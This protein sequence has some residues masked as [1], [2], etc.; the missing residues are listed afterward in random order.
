MQALPNIL[1]LVAEDMCP[2][3]GCYGNPD[4]R[5]PNL[6]RLASEGALYENAHSF[7]PICAPARSCLITGVYPTSM[8][9]Q[10]MRSKV[11]RPAAIRL[12]TEYLRDA[13]YYCFNGF[14]QQATQYG[15]LSAEGY[16]TKFDYNFVE[17]EERNPLPAWD[18][19]SGFFPEGSAAHWRNRQ[20]G[21]PFF[22]QIGFF[23][24][25]QSQYGTRHMPDT[26]CIPLSRVTPAERRSPNNVAVPPY[27]PDCD[28]V[29]QLWAEYHD[30]ITEM[31]HQVGEVLGALE[32]DGLT[33][34]TVVFF[35]GD[36]GMGVVGGKSWLWDQGTHVPLIVRVPEDLQSV[37]PI[38]SGDVRPELVS[39]E[40]LAPT[41]LQI[42][43]IDPPTHMQ[44]R[45]IFGQSA[46]EREYVF[47]ARDRQDHCPEMIR[48]V[49]DRDYQYIRN[50][51]PDQGWSHSAYAW[52]HAPWALSDWRVAAEAGVL[53]GR[54]R[55][56]FQSRKPVEE[57]YD[58]R[59]DPHQM[60]NLTHDIDHRAVLTRLQSALRE[61]MIE[62]GDLGLLS[63][64][65]LHRRSGRS[66]PMEMASDR[67][68]YPMEVILGAAWSATDPATDISALLTL[69]EHTDPAIRRWGAIG[70]RSIGDGAAVAIP[71]L[72]DL[73]Q[74]DS[75]PDV[76][77]AAAEALAR[78]G[79]VVVAVE[80]LVALAKSQSGHLV[81]AALWALAQI[82]D[83]AKGAIATIESLRIAPR[84]SWLRVDEPA[85]GE[86]HLEVLADL[87]VDR[88]RPGVPRRQGVI[89]Q[90]YADVDELGSILDKPLTM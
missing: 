2:D 70:L 59:S 58:L 52:K 32:N 6:D 71:A 23:I 87:V 8:G 73:A 53:E 89:S 78:V 56:F 43:G 47:G 88:L 5:S 76:R 1:W 11:R 36:N 67:N 57:L 21:Q 28:G 74:K 14:S 39:F 38:R 24:T 51:L 10:H 68:L 81:M 45:P 66:T 54:Q 64:Y 16:Q 49:R 75:A 63:E 55:V 69:L 29:R 3:L 83:G 27:Q 37:I 48:T 4:S 15:P 13:G 72:R 33:E 34:S 60:H 22:G 90:Y 62:T 19:V 18:A 79:Q 20:P 65:D 30:C 77:L 25:H 44:G 7:A 31:D 12:V 26:R 35:F 85:Q 61:W 80:V 17:P 50:F 41:L 84:E 40:D 42:A 82:G 86:P 46:G 9:S